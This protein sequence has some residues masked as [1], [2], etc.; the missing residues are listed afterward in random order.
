VMAMRIW[1]ILGG[2]NSLAAVVAGAYAII[3]WKRTRERVIFLRSAP[4]TKCGMRWP[5]AWLASHHKGGIRRV[6]AIAG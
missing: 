6:T 3:A 5:S 2:L 1:L 4:N